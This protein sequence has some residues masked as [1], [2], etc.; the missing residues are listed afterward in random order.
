MH[1]LI[2][3]IKKRKV[4]KLKKKSRRMLPFPDVLE[5][6]VVSIFMMTELVSV[7]CRGDL[8]RGFVSV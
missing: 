6:S 4:R 1:L 2:I 7:G 5:D 8:D 3:P